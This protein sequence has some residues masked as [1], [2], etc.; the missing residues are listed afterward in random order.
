MKQRCRS[1]AFTWVIT[2]ILLTLAAP[3]AAQ[4]VCWSANGHYYEA[5][6]ARNISWSSA[7]TAAE[8]RSYAGRRG[9]LATITSAEENAFVWSLLRACGST[10]NQFFIGGYENPPGSRRWHWVTGEPFTYTNWAPGEPS[11]P[12]SETVIALGLFCSAQWNDVPPSGSWGSAGYI[13]EYGG[14][15]GDV[16]SNGCVGAADLLQLLFAFGQTGLN[17]ADL[18]CDSVVN[19]ADLLIL[20]F[21]FGQGCGG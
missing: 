12:G 3:V 21:N 19:N 14:V 5:V 4:P 13:V 6:S 11:S 18:N 10:S 16:D 8:G 2:G 1:T 9:Y 20:L 7:R 17:A 15:A